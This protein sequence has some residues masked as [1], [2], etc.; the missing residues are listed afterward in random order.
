M[1]GSGAAGLAAIRRLYEAGVKAVCLEA[2]DRI[3][4]RVNT[5]PFAGGVVDLGAMV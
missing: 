5:V 1:I 2:A 3:G 4:G